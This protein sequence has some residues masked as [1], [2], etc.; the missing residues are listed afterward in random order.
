MADQRSSLN[1]QDELEAEE[2]RATFS[3]KQQVM[4]MYCDNAK[5]YIQLSGAA[6]GLTLTFAHEI[7]NIPKDQN[8]ADGWMISVWMLFLLAI[9]MGAFYQYKAVKLLEQEIDWQS[10]DIWS[11]VAPGTVYGIMLAAFYGGATVFTIY[12]IVRLRH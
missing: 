5:T 7:L 3:R 8:I 10:S 12:A 1:S 6:L 9:I 2:R 4:A 11:W